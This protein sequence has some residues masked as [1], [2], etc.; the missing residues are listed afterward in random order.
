[1][2]W[3]AYALRSVDDVN[4]PEPHL[5]AE[6]RA[7]FEQAN[8]ELKI[9][10]G[11]GGEIIDGELG[12]ALSKKCLLLATPIACYE[13]DNESGQLCW[14]PELVRQ[15]YALADWNYRI[16]D[17]PYYDEDN[18][19]DEWWIRHGK[20]EARLFLETCSRHGYAILFTW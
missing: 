19:E 9:Q 12:G 1:M 17:E 18:P 8:A 16:E 11:D 7:I 6:M 13:P 5:D 3:D 15:A 4:S 14:S 20:C 10:V 2:G